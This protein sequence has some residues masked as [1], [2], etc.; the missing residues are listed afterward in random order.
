MIINIL[1][2]VFAGYECYKMLNGEA[3]IKLIR[4]LK[5]GLED[6]G[7]EPLFERD[8]FLKRVLIIEVAYIVFA[9]TLI[10]TQY[11][12]FPIILFSLSFLLVLIETIMGINRWIFAAGSAICA[13]LLVNIMLT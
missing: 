10:F 3:F 6:P 11:W 13:L 8:P 12:Y 5:A 2:A 4:K 9:L 1:A 7:K